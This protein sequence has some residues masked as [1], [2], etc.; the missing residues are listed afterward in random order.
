MYDD[1]LDK[2]NAWID[3]FQEKGSGFVFKSIK[4]SNVK[5]YKYNNQRASSYIPLQFKSSNIINVQNTKDNKCFLWSILAKLYPANSDKERVSKYKPYE[6]KINMNGIDYP[7][8]IKDI[9]KVE[10]QNNNISINVFA[11]EDQTN[12]QSLY[13]VYVSNVESGNTGKIPVPHIID[14]LFIENNENTHYCLIKDLDSFRYDKN[15]HKQYTCRNC[16]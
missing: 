13:P 5:Q 15:K 4:S 10:K 2:F 1:L 12:K 11:L 14:L 8:K 6:D 9:P 16:M 3:G 7:V